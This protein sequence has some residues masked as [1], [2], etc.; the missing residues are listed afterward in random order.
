MLKLVAKI[1]WGTGNL[2]EPETSSHKILKNIKMKRDSLQCRN[3]RATISTKWSMLTSL[4]INHTSVI[5]HLILLK[6]GQTWFLSVLFLAKISDLILIMRK[7]YTVKLRGILQNKW[8]VLNNRVSV[9]QKTNKQTR[10][11]K[12]RQQL[13]E[14]WDHELNPVPEKKNI[15][16]KNES[17]LRIE[18]CI[19]C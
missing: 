17:Q 6:K 8:P 9:T 12:M 2:H 14:I 16:R 18:L 4:I 19:R 3:M 5:Y 1:G 7:Y 10:L 15:S 11:S 13:I